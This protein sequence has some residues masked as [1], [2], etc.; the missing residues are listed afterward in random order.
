MRGMLNVA[1]AHDPAALKGKLETLL[2][3]MKEIAREEILTV[4]RHIARTTLLSIGE[5][6]EP[7]D[8]DR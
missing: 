8:A 3:A 4:P 5:N 6:W 2:A 1:R 7:E